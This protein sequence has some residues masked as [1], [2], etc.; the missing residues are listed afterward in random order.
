ME[1]V[2]SLCVVVIEIRGGGCGRVNDEKRTGLNRPSCKGNRCIFPLYSAS[3]HFL[4]SHVVV[5]RIV[6][7]V[8]LL[9]NRR[10]RENGEQAIS[11]ID[12]TMSHLYRYL[13]SPS[14]P[15][16]HVAVGVVV[17]FVVV[18]VVVVAVLFKIR[19]GQ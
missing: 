2:G 11:S 1:S 3:F 13:H 12:L 15:H 10:V 19:R 5:V 6:V 14:S 18:V 7:V 9:K 4:S 17:V 8:V 16:P